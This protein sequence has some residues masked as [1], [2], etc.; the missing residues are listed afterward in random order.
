MSVT[1][2]LRVLQNPRRSKSSGSSALDLP[3]LASNAA[4]DEQSLRARAAGSE[5]GVEA[6]GS[7]HRS[8]HEAIEDALEKR[9]ARAV[10]ETWEG[11]ELSAQ[12]PWLD[13]ITSLPVV[14]ISLD[15]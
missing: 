12:F 4:M 9:A 15:V 6:G 8:I 1:C 7:E 14:S 11:W 2:L 3:H 13:P 5:A 10:G